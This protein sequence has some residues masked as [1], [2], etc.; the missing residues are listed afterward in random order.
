MKKKLFY[1]TGLVI[2]LSMILSACGTAATPT[3]APA[4]AA[5][6]TPAP[7]AVPAA[8]NTAAPTAVPPTP[9]PT[10]YPLAS[11]QAGKTCVRWFIGLGTGTD[12]GQIPTEQGV[13]DDFNASQSSVQLIMELIPYASAK[14]TLATEIA[15]GNGPDIVGPVGWAGSNAFFDQWGDLSPYIKAG[16][17]DTAVFDKSLV[18]MYHPETAQVGLPFAVYPS[19]MEFNTALF[20]QAGLKYPPAKYGDKYTFPDGT[21]ADWTWAT[22]A[23]VGQYLTVDKAGKNATEAGFDKSSIVQYGFTWNF[24]NQ[25]EY[26]GAFWAGGSELVAGGTK[27][28]YKAAVPQA[29]KDSFTWYYN[30]IWGAQPFIPNNAVEQ[31]PDFGTG[32]V[33]NSGKVAMTIE[34]SWYTCCMSNVKT[35]D[36]AAMPTYNGKV[37]GRIDADTF[38]LLKTSKNPQAAFTAMVYLET[39]GVKRLIIG[40]AANPPAYGAVPAIGADRQP[41]LDAK[42]AQF[43]WVKNM[44]TLITGLQYPDVPSAEGYVPNFNDAWDRNT[45]F[46]NLL[47]TTSGLDLNKEIATLESDLTTIYNK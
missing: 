25:P 42:A 45:K 32:N 46:G 10:A 26:W 44:S 13:V 11:C 17:F 31:S 28:T 6:D 37:G 35:W 27:G 1:L 47:V 38:R 14:N 41:F 16:K 8:T 3:A 15:S 5:T 22:L 12:A 4:A 23:K 34:P 24:E 19:A 18:A 43:P 9:V 39:T 7:T 36:F 21:T 33:F 40:S 29:W 20:D 30:G 2:A